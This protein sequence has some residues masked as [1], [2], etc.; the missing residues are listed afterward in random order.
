MSPSIGGRRHAPSWRLARYASLSFAPRATGHAVDC[1]SRRCDAGHEGHCLITSP[2]CYRARPAYSAR[3]SAR[4]CRASLRRPLILASFAPPLSPDAITAAHRAG[5]SA[6]CKEAGCGLLRRLMATSAGPVSARLFAAPYARQ[7]FHRQP[8]H[9]ASREQVAAHRR[10]LLKLVPLAPRP[11][12]SV[13]VSPC[14]LRA[15]RRVLFP[16][17]TPIDAQFMPTAH[18]LIAADYRRR[19][20]PAPSAT[21]AA[22][23]LHAWPGASPSRR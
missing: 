22:I 12:G 4:T 13:A 15:C 6:R 19:G 10:C 23:F 14:L 2:P 5:R 7:R 11:V 9:Y 3:P 8:R 21:A 16:I 1:R 18:G 20:S 17:S